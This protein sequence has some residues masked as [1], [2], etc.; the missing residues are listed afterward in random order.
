MELR[1]REVE[2]ADLDRQEAALK[3]R[4]VHVR[5]QTQPDG[6]ERLE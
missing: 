2:L 6:A 4:L 1:W 5:E 3:L